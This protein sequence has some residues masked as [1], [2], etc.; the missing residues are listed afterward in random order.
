MQDILEKAQTFLYENGYKV[1][2]SL[3]LLTGDHERFEEDDALWIKGDV[4]PEGYFTFT[5]GDFRDVLPKVSFHPG[6]RSSYAKE[7]WEKHKEQWEEDKRKALIRKKE[8]HERAE[9]EARDIWNSAHPRS[10][11][12]AGEY[13]QRK[14]IAGIVSRYTTEGGREVDLIPMYRLGEGDSVRFR[15]VQKIL[16]DGTKLFIKGQ[17]VQGTFCPVLE[18]APSD[19]GD[20]AIAEGYATSETVARLSRCKTYSCF[21]AGNL[22]HVGDALRIA[23]KP[24]QLF[25]FADNDHRTEKDHGKNT[26][27]EAAEECAEKLGAKIIVPQFTAEEEWAS[28]WN[29]YFLIHG[30]EATRAEIERQIKVQTPSVR[31]VE[32]KEKRVWSK[33]KSMDMD[34]ILDLGKEI[35]DIRFKVFIDDRA[36]ILYNIKDIK[37]KELV[38]CHN[39]ELVIK[40]LSQN[41]R[42]LTGQSPVI[43]FCQVVYDHWKIST[44]SLKAEPPSFTWS[45]SDDWTFKKLDFT[46]TEGA[47]PAW[48][49]FL[50]R[51]SSPEDFMAFIWSIF[52][53]KS[54]SRQYL[55]LCD[56][57]GQGGKTT[58]INTLGEIFGNAYTA[59]NNTFVSGPAARWLLGNLYGKRLVGWPDVKNTKF[60]MTEILRNIT[61]GDDVTVEFKGQAPFSTRMYLKLIM[62]S[63]HEP[64]ISS[65]G[66]DLS[67][68]IRVD[69]KENTFG[70]NDPLWREKIR[71]E[72]PFFLYECRKWY[73]EKC[74]NHGNIIL[75]HK[76]T[77]LTAESTEGIEAHLEDIVMRRIEFGDYTINS[78]DWVKFY[79][80]ERLSN[81]EVS[82]LKDYL[83]RLN[84]SVR[85]KREGNHK[86]TIYHG[87]KI[88]ELRGQVVGEFRF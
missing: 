15:G 72:L 79:K 54:V 68:L 21:H 86:A 16:P 31:V 56:P 14:R 39:E 9:R 58:I 22:L 57:H 42:E 85:K 38:V 61:S 13:C 4:K 45:D 81:H 1:R 67:R 62:A 60:C 25:I 59:I 2:L 49:E 30:E 78:S 36:T 76:T 20:Y 27:L 28:D 10:S 24:K 87:F 19:S 80:E 44:E 88:R 71:A 65:G 84:P 11:G 48:E 53:T 41:I 75:S 64:S 50:Y 29:D 26:G 23:F 12:G 63:N 52:E 37:K 6:K 66:A 77:E 55:Y 46:P 40:R 5:V 73:R 47:F 70:K 18:Y 74:P 83:K 3:D 43:K 69:L 82:N 34:E 32:E 7:E 51:C 17:E 35:L 8:G 33:H